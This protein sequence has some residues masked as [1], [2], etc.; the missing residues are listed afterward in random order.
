[1]PPAKSIPGN[2][3][4]RS[5]IGVWQSAHSADRVMYRPYA[6]LSS[7]E[8]RGCGAASRGLVRTIRFNGKLNFRSG[9]LAFSIAFN[10]HRVDIVFS[11]RAVVGI[12]HQWKQWRAVFRYTGGHRTQQ[13]GIAPLA[14][15]GRRNVLRI[16]HAGGTEIERFS[17]GTKQLILYRA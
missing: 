6:T 4:P 17:S 8:G 5:S 16:E 13:L 15:R 9:M 10:E 7:G 11:H 1:M 14:Q 3:V 12:R 2:G